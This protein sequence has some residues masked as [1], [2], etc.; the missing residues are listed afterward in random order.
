LDPAALCRKAIEAAQAL[1]LL[2]RGAR[3]ERRAPLAALEPTLAERA[4]ILQRNLRKPGVAAPRGEGLEIAEQQPVLLQR[5]R[6]DSSAVLGVAKESMN[7]LRE[8]Y[9]G[10][11]GSGGL[12]KLL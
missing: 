7:T 12:C 2:Q 10:V 8:F 9:P 11:S 1:K 4:E 5:D 3:A 6:R